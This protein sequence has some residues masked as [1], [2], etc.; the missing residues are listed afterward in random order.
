MR[1]PLR[2]TLLALSVWAIGLPAAQATDLLEVWQAAQQHDREHAVARAAY[3]SAQPQRDQATAL[4]RPNV[5]LTA[6]AGIATNETDTQGAQFAAPGMARSNG[7]DFSSSVTGGTATRWGVQASQP[8]Y[9]PQRRAQ[10][11]Q[12]R[13]AADQ[14]ELQWQAAQQTLILR[15]AQRYL[16]IAIA[17]KALRVLDQQFTAVQRT[18]TEVQDRFDLGSAPITDTHEARAQLAG[19]RAQRLAAQTRLE[20]Q[21]RLLAD[22]TGLSASALQPQLPGAGVMATPAR[23]LPLWQAEA[24]A[25]NPELKMQRVAVELARSQASQHRQGASTSVDLVAQ[26]G[27]ERLRGSG[28]FGS[29]ARNKGSNALIGVQLTMPLWT[30]GWRNAKE[31]QA[32]RQQEQAQAQ[33]EST[34]ATVAQ[35]VHAAWLGL[36]TGRE[37]VQALSEALQASQ[38]RRD[39]TQVGYEVGHRT[40]LD[41]LHAENDTASAHLA[42][43]QAQADLL[44]DSLRLAALAGQLD[45]TALRAANLLLEPTVAL[46]TTDNH[47]RP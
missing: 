23:E 24:E 45:E 2:S 37:R 7:V 47:T 42:L 1:Q 9:N 5:G 14:A 28:D 4:W 27:Q 41:L 15:T 22:S 16:E 32:L 36:S 19:L 6:T 26:A 33:L 43:A 10:Q 40:T 12:L 44:L 35:Q 20:I 11:Q 29:G 13:L 3:A 30:G 34:Q 18:A 38:S 8:L 46:S 17:E 25:A 21:R 39:A 31:A